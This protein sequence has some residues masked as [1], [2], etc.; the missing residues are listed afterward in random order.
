VSEQNVEAVLR[1]VEAVN[2]GD[3]ERPLGGA[4]EDLVF[5]PRRS[6]IEGPYLGRKGL[7]KFLEDTAE[8]FDFFQLDLTE[9]RDLG[10]RVLGIGTVRVRAR[11]GGA[12]TAVPMAC[13]LTFRDG[14]LAHFKDY[15]DRSKALEVSGLSD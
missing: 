5:E 12:E 8:T 6:A 14:L 9:L 2:S 15:G 7:R 4:T 3:Y 1:F 13:I 11:E 10:D